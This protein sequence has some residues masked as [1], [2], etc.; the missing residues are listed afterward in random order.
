MPIKG[1]VST[2]ATTTYSVVLVADA[3]AV[4]GLV[5]VTVVRGAP[6]E[7]VLPQLGSLFQTSLRMR[8][9]DPRRRLP[10][11]NRMPRQTLTWIPSGTRSPLNGLSRKTRR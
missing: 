5:A 8:P 4:E 6:C 1:A 11:V 3:D 7:E 10:R 9:L 2:Q